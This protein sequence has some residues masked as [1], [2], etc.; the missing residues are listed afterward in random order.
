LPKEKGLARMYTTHKHMYAHKNPD[1]Y[2]TGFLNQKKSKAEGIFLTL[3]FLCV[4]IV[5]LFV[6]HCSQKK[7][8][9]EGKEFS[10][11]HHTK[12]DGKYG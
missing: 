4:W 5:G 7:V 1:T 2:P 9:W 10:C 8:E 3:F 6:A 11:T 12:T